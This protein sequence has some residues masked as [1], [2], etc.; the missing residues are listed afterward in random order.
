MPHRSPP[1][2]NPRIRSVGHEGTQR[3]A[4]R[5]LRRSRC[6]AAACLIGVLMMTATPIW[7]SAQSL[8]RFVADVLEAIR[9][10]E[11][12]DGKFLSHGPLTGTL[13]AG[14]SASVEIHTCAGIEYTAQGLCD[15]D[16]THFDLT[17]YNASADVLDSDALFD[18]FPVLIFTP[19]ESGVTTLSV[20][21]VSCT[22][23]CDWGV[24]LFIADATAPAAPGSRDGGAST[25][26][27]DWDR[28]VGTYRG[29][30]GDTTILRHE[31]RLTMLFPSF[32][33][34]NGGIGVLR[35][36]GSTHIFRLE[37]DG[38]STDGDRVRFVVND[39]G[40]A[41]AVFVAGHESRRVG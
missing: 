10:R 35:P 27:L 7:V 41:T 5:L 9:E 15:G 32:Q 17:A 18:A 40:K 22:G 13:D 28:Y 1:Q 33:W 21:M 29:S 31:G 38:S 3:E 11:A 20:E 2:T 30:G 8:D 23:S 36:T 25:W 4:S 6:R 14:A 16:C 19:A 26:S 24:Q 12:E 39:T 37:S 34:H